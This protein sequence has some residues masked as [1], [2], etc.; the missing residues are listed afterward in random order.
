MGRNGLPVLML[1]DLDNRTCPSGMIAEWLKAP[2]NPGFLFR[3]C[4]RE[5]DAWLMAD[6]ER[7]AEFLGIGVSRIALKPEALSDPKA[8]LIRLSQTAA[9]REMRT[10]FKPL[11]S[12]TIGP[13]HNEY[14][15]EFVSGF[16]RPSVADKIAPSLGRARYRIRE[17]ATQVIV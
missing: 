13:R 15:K 10:G 8:E 2:L 12:A 11:R 6:R 16:W 14:L 9:K 3:I 4:V 7:F 17:I 5:I 1:T